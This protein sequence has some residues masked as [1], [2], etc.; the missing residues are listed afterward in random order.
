MKLNH[1]NSP[2]ARESGFMGFSAQV[3]WL[4]QED[5]HSYASVHMRLLSLAFDMIMVLFIMMLVVM[6]VYGQAWLMRYGAN[7]SLE[8]YLT[9]L[10]VPC[11]YFVGCWSFSG[12]TPGKMLLGQSVVDRESGR[13]PGIIQ[14]FI[15][16]CGY[17]LNLFSFGLGVLGLLDQDRPLGWHDRISGTIVVQHQK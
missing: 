15:R 11:L 6:L 13:L 17:G 10:L 16:F 4:P 9:L 5:E 3:G 1:P 14:S 12:A 8:F 7:P 2:S